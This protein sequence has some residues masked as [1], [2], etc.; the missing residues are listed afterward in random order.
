VHF[1]S[2][3]FF[4]RP[5]LKPQKGTNDECSLPYAGNTAVNNADNTV[6]VPGIQEGRGNTFTNVDQGQN[7]SGSRGE[8]K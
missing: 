5:S 3:F 7:Q 1:G 4:Q 8:N 2:D 6:G